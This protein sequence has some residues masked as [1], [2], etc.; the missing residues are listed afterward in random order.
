MN[1]RLSFQ[2]NFRF[3]GRVITRDYLTMSGT[4]SHSIE[5]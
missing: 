1:E 2:L 3:V 4:F 5:S